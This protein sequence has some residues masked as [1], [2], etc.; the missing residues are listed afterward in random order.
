MKR[1][2]LITYV[3]KM[4]MLVSILTIT[5]IGIFMGMGD[6]WFC[7]FCLALLNIVELADREI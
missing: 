3:L 6:I 5:S 4:L 2:K 7:V 1:F